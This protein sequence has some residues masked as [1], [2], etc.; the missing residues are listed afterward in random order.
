[1]A[2]TG[3]PISTATCTTK[4]HEPCRLS[5]A[6]RNASSSSRLGSAGS[7]WNAAMMSPSSDARMMQPARQIRAMFTGCRSY[8]YSADAIFNMPNPCAYDVTLLA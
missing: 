2:G 4:R 8:L 1:M 7:R 5:T 6:C 3:M